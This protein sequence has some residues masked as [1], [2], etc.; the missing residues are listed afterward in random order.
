VQTLP[1][2]NAGQ[3]NSLTAKLNAA[4]ASASRGDTRAC[5]NQLNAFLN[6]LQAYVNTGK[7]SAGDAAT[8]RAAVHAVKGS[9]GTYNRFLEWWP[10]GF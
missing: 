8:L 9:I 6:E 5:N 1:S 4:A 2:L 3:K 7:V 10:L